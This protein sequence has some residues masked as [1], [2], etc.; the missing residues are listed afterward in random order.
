MLSLELLDKHIKECRKCVDSGVESKD[1]LDDLIDLRK[2]L[3]CASEEEWAAY[4]HMTNHLP[5]DNNDSTLI[6]LKGQLLIEQLVRK[7]IESK[8]PNPVA[9][10]K[11]S[12]NAAQCNALAES[13]CI[14]SEGGKWL[15]GQVNELNTIRNK[16]AHNLDSEKFEQRISNLI[17][18]VSNKQKLDDRSLSGVVACLYGMML[19]F[20][21]RLTV[22][23]K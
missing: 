3:A 2:H 14:E 18:T 19:E 20:T 15:W 22:S 17:S 8:L 6:I 9:F 10:N 21:H 23:G 13:L 11:I 5:D 12:L 4:N 7:F 16:L 1:V